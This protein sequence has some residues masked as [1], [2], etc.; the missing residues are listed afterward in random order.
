LVLANTLGFA[1]GVTLGFALF[2][3]FFFVAQQLPPIT[4]RQERRSD[5]RLSASIPSP[6]G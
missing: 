5:L 1:V 6:K 3:G 2:I 4:S